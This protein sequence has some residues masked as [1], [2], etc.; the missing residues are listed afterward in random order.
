[1]YDRNTRVGKVTREEWAISVIGVHCTKFTKE[2]IEILC[3]E[4]TKTKQN[5][6]VSLGD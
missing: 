5:N 4:K 3:W 2:L 1:V 6:Q